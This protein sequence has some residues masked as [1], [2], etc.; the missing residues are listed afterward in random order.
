MFRK[1][2]AAVAAIKA[3]IARRADYDERDALKATAAELY[4]A[5][6]LPAILP[7]SW[8]LTTRSSLALGDL[9]QPMVQAGS[10]NPQQFLNYIV[11]TGP[12]GMPVSDLWRK[13]ED[14]LVQAFA[15]RGD[16]EGVQHAKDFV[17]QQSHAG[18]N[19]HLMAADQAYN[20]GDMV[21]AAQHLAASHAF[22]RDGTI[23][24][25]RTN[26]RTITGQRVDES[27]PSRQLGPSVTID[28]NAIRGLLNQTTNPS[29]YLDT[30]RKEQAAAA[31]A[32]LKEAHGDYY[33]SLPGT[34]IGVA[35]MQAQSRQNVA[36]TNAQSRLD[37]Q[38]A[39]GSQ[40]GGAQQRQIDKETED[41]FGSLATGQDANVAS[42]RMSELYSGIRMNGVSP[43]QAEAV[44]RGLSDKTLHLLRRSDG[45]YEAVDSKTQQPTGVV[46]PRAIGARF[47]P[48]AQAGQTPVG[49][50]AT[51]GYAMG[52]GVRQNLSGTVM[53]GQSS[54]AAP[55]QS[56][57][58]PIN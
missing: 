28:G 19:A 2:T 9:P 51:S 10:Q 12:A 47:D 38:A 43:P 24:Q 33:G 13:A 17:L 23:G 54:A 14:S 31:D 25:F 50:G 1:T 3:A 56:S 40:I 16:L 27:D 45:N 49:A 52:A 32:R 42:G 41:K 53:P 22:F 35:A 37:V 6:V 34:R 21:T 26:G 15:S 48:Q 30:L 39:K 36:D 55:S 46:I 44:T 57:A 8:R 18:A 20:R 29:Q 5:E 11:Q 58:L 7:G 4:G